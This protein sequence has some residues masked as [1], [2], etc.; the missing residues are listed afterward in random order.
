MGEGNLAGNVST[1]EEDSEI[2]SEFL[3]ELEQLM[4][5]YRV[6]KVDIGWKHNPIG[7]R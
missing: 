7:I 5:R 3:L 1:E 6:D 2:L 4:I